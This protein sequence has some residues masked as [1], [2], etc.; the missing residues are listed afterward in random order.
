MVSRKQ[1]FIRT[2]RTSSPTKIMYAPSLVTEDADPNTSVV[3]QPQ[4]STASSSET[5]ATD[6]AVEMQPRKTKTSNRISQPQ[7]STASS[8]ETIV[9]DPAVEMQ[10]RKLSGILTKNE[11]QFQFLM[12]VVQDNRRLYPNAL[13]QTLLKNNKYWL[14]KILDIKMS[15]VNVIQ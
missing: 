3:S 11:E 4:S 5:I 6:P 14:L 1:E 2:T 12:Q 8:S 15:T 9:T 7:S 10:P 13:K